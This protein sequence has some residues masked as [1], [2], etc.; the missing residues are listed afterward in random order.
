MLLLS[1]IQPLPLTTESSH[2]LQGEDVHAYT[3]HDLL[4]HYI[5]V[6]MDTALSCKQNISHPSV[7]C[8]WVLR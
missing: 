6:D 1:Y 5:H 7:L 4:N 3:M 2:L 8:E